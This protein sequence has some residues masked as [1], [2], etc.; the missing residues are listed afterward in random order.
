MDI[1]KK[2]ELKNNL[3]FKFLSSKIEFKTFKVQNWSY[4]NFKVQKL[5]LNFFKDQNYIFRLN[6]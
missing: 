3:K 6:F 4:N 1:L 5:N 2:I